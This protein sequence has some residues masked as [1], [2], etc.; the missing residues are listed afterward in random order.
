MSKWIILF[1]GVIQLA[2]LLFSKF[3]S[4]NAERKKKL[5]EAEKE[6]KDGI[7]KKDPSTITAAFDKLNRL[8]K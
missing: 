1:G 6:L 3:F 4:R 2:L 7:K 5:E 8:T